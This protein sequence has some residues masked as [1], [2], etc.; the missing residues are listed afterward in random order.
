MGCHLWGGR[1][2]GREEERREER[3]G[4]RTER[5]VRKMS[6]SDLPM[7]FTPVDMGSLASAQEVEAMPLC[8]FPGWKV[9]ALLAL[10]SS[11]GPWV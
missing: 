10:V 3:K 6:K 11:C 9:P 4:V 7:G 5:V 8:L 2:Q 1:E